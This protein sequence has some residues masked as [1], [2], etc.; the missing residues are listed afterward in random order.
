MAPKAKMGVT[1][2]AG[3]GEK[4]IPVRKTVTKKENNKALTGPQLFL[5][6]PAVTCNACRQNTHSPVDRDSSGEHPKPLHWTKVL[7]YRQGNKVIRQPIGKE[8][9]PCCERLARFE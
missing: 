1:S 5:D 9:Y 8:C 7:R 3:D 6:F 4:K 2:K